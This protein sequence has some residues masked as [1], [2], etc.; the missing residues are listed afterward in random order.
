MWCV[1]TL[2][3][4]YIERMEDILMLYAKPYDP[5]EPVLCTDEKSKQLIRDTR[6]MQETNAGRP[7]RRDYEYKRN[8]TRNIFVTVEPK[9]GYRK[10]T[11]TKQRRKADFATEIQRILRLPRYK[12]ARTIHLVLD[13]LNTHFERSFHET[14]GHAVADRLLERIQLHHTPKHASWLNMAEI[15]IGIMDRQCIRGRIPEEDALTKKITAWQ[16]VRNEERALIQWK[17]TV[18]DARKKM[19]YEGSKLS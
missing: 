6:P 11:V 17:F 16:A 18:A 9:G 15:E 5:K 4:E 13:N 7:R 1:P 2:T 8:G 12:K 10:A 19:K 3:S 14:F